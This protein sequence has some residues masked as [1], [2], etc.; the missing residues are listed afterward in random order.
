MSYLRIEDLDLARKRVMIRQ[1]LN[2][3][4]SDGRV[5]SDARIRASIPTIELALEK[6]AA[7]I[8]LS[9]L[10]RPVEGEPDPKFSMQ[11]VADRMSELLGRPVRLEKTGWAV[12]MSSRVKSFFVKTSA[13]TWAKR[14][15]TRTWRRPTRR[16]ATSS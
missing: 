3:P 15:T 1:D 8:L 6:G 13:S 12:S 11:P 4:V 10:G 16:C 5:S 14:R 9:H 2:V 7:V